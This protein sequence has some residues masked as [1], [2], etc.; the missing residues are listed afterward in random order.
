MKRPI[1]LE[2]ITRVI[3]FSQ[4]NDPWLKVFDWQLSAVSLPSESCDW[5][6]IFWNGMWGYL[7]FTPSLSFHCLESV[8]Y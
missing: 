3:G 8:R 7:S 6:A 4:R 5:V 1:L 2:D